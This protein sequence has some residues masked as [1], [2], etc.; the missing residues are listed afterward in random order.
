MATLQTWT[1]RATATM[2]VAPP[3]TTKRLGGRLLNQA[4]R[5][6]SPLQLTKFTSMDLLPMGAQA[7]ERTPG[8]LKGDEDAGTDRSLPS[9]ESGLSV[10][11]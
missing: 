6:S 5:Q 7:N 2:R 4:D 9:T 11:T 10:T 8:C 1:V 3:E